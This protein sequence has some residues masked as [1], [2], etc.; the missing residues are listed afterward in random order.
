MHSPVERCTVET[1]GTGIN[2]STRPRRIPDQAAA[3]LTWRGH[4]WQ[5]DDIGGNPPDLMISI[6]TIQPNSE[7]GVGGGGQR[8][9]KAYGDTRFASPFLYVVH[10]LAAMACCPKVALVDTTNR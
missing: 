6:L 3:S 8:M 9:P 1:F 2:W 5:K 4:D 7:E 10:V